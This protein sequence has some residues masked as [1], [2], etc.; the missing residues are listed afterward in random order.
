MLK[1]LA[2]KSTPVKHIAQ[3]FPAIINGCSGNDAVVEKINSTLEAISGA[4]GLDAGTV[5]F[6]YSPKEDWEWTTR[7]LYRACQLWILDWLSPIPDTGASKEVF[8]ARLLHG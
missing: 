5:V 2:F 3:I 6:L 8:K 4:A 7:K 1:G